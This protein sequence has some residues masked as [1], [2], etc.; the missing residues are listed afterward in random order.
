M[1]ATYG[2]RDDRR[3]SGDLRTLRWAAT[4]SA[5]GDGAFVTTSAVFLTAAAGLTPGQVGLDLTVAWASGFVL[6]PVLGALADRVGLRTCAVAWSMLV[7]GA[8]VVLALSRRPGLVTVTSVLV[9]YAVAQ[10]GLGGL[11]QTLV[12]TVASKDKRVTIRARMHVAVNAGLAVGC[13]MGGL[14]L[15]AGTS[16]G[17]RAVLLMDAGIFA[18]TAAA[19][20]RLAVRPGHGS[21][22]TRPGLAVL[23][24]RPYLAMTLLTGAL[25][26]YLPMLSV[27][28][29]LYLTRHTAAPGWTV[30]AVFLVNTAGVLL[31]QLPAARRV[32]TLDRARRSVRLAG[33]ALALSCL[34][35]AAATT[36]GPA[37]S[38]LWACAG[39]AVQV[40]GEVMLAAGAWYT[41]FELADPHHPGQWQA[42]SAAAHPL[43][44]AVGPL[45]LVALLQSASVAGWSVLAAGFLA[46]GALFGPTVTWATLS[47]T[48][49]IGAPRGPLV[50]AVPTS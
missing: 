8:L 43:A 26:L 13:A 25:Y 47:R 6:S 40:V 28:L 41:G 48:R 30:A 18:L 22:A 1:E 11:R 35:F 10:S 39:T 20:S 17:Y 45:A 37:T 50:A 16:T 42:V 12:V 19:L 31:L 49:A 14:A 24:D 9:V 5:V 33:T 2:S 4:G 34:L 23:R 44:R 27:A 38:V 15:L 32:T 46:A 29:P 36:G 21:H 7:S 3:P